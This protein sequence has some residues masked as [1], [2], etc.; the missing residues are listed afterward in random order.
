LIL[1]CFA[2]LEGLDFNHGSLKVSFGQAIPAIGWA[3]SLI[4][5]EHFFTELFATVWIGQG[6]KEFFSAQ[7]LYLAKGFLD[8]SPVGN[9]GFEPLKLFLGQGDTDGLTFDLA[10]PLI[11]STATAGYPVLGWAFTNPTDFRAQTPL[12]AVLMMEETFQ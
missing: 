2:N 12:G 4:D 10:G 7:P 8:R 9:G 11:G 5:P 6:C 1:R 3:E